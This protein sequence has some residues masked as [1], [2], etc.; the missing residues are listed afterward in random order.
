MVNAD[1][2][3]DSLFAAGVFV[4]T[5]IKGAERYFCWAFFKPAELAF[6]RAKGPREKIGLLAL[7]K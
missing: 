2:N 6:G 3:A 5:A 1:K 7:A 4:C